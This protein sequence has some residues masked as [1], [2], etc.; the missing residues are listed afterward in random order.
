MAVILLQANLFLVH[1]ASKKWAIA[2]EDLSSLEK[3]VF[4]LLTKQ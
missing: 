1:Q 3:D 2:V 4:R